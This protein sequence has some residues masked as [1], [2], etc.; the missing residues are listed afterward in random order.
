MKGIMNIFFILYIAVSLFILLWAVLF[1][2]F[3]GMK[4]FPTWTGYIAYPLSVIIFISQKNVL[5][6]FHNKDII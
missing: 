4:D 5:Q 6:Y 1:P 3:M 2:L